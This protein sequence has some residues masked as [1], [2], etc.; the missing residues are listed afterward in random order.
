[1]RSED[2]L[3]TNV[4]RAGFAVDM[5]NIVRERALGGERLADLRRFLGLIK[6]LVAYTKDASLRIYGVADWSLLR[7]SDLLSDDE[8]DRLHRWRK[9][10][11]IEVLEGADGRLIELAETGGLMVVCFDNYL[12]FHRS[13]PWLPGNEDRFLLPFLGPRGISVRPREIPIRPEWQ[14]S[15]KEEESLLKKE[16]L[17]GAPRRELL[18]RLWLCAVPG[19]P[20]F[21]K[22]RGDHQPLPRYRSGSARCPSHGQPLTDIG[23]RP[24]RVQVKVRV[25]DGVATRFTLDPGQTMN[26]GR[27]PGPEGFALTPELGVAADSGIS[28]DHAGLRWTGSKLFVTDHSRFGTHV[29]RNGAE[30]FAL[31]RGR[32]CPVR[33]GDEIILADGVEL[34]LSGREFLFEGSSPVPTP[35]DDLAAEAAR[36]TRLPQGGQDA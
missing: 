3:S 24:R 36:V 2:Y 20:L 31:A 34:L 29:R 14:L 28:R 30:P 19:C 6:G 17:Y 11:L 13:H 23:T 16:G 4:M 18:N 12:D 9:A 26:V 7:K 35:S 1:M 21:G 22:D 33:A 15:R 10:G 27:A 25:G 8:R 32:S 5:S